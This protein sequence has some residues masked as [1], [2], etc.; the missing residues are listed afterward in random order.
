VNS[1]QEMIMKAPRYPV[2][3]PVLAAMVAAATLVL[4]ANAASAATHS[5]RGHASGYQTPQ[6]SSPGDP[7]DSLADGRQSYPNPDRR[8]YLPD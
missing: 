4:T 8:L 1:V 7:Y 2:D 5:Q 6:Y 3:T